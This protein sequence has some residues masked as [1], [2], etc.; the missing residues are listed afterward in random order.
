MKLHANRWMPVLAASAMTGAMVVAAPVSPAAAAPTTSTATFA[1]TGAVQTW[2]VPAGVSAA[3]FQLQ[4]AAGANGSGAQ[5]GNGGAGGTLSAVV[6]LTPNNAV[7][8]YVGGQSGFNG[9]GNG[10][11]TGGNG[12]DATDIRTAVGV[13][14]SR[15]LVAG[16]GGG[17]G[18]A[19]FYPVASGVGGAGSQTGQNGTAG[20]TQ[21]SSGGAAGQGG[22]SSNALGTPGGTTGSNIQG[23]GGGGGGGYLG[24]TGGGAGGACSSCQA[25]SGGGGGGGSSFAPATASKVVYGSGNATGNGSVVVNW[26]N[27]STT[28]VPDAQ[29]GLPFQSQLAASGGTNTYTWS[30]TSGTLPAGLTLSA[31]GLISGTP[32]SL[33]AAAVTV[34]AV[35]GNGATTQ[36]ALVVDVVSASAVVVDRTAT[37]V[38]STSATGNGAVSAPGAAVTSIYCRISTSASS[39]NSGTKV[40]A[41]PATASATASNQP[42]TCKFTGLQPNRAYLYLFYA[43][44]GGTTSVSASPSAFKT[45]AFAPQTANLKGRPTSL[46]NKGLT[47]LLSSRTKT[48]AGQSV[49][50]SL[51]VISKKGKGTVAKLTKTKKGK[52]VVRTYG[53]IARLQV[54]YSAPAKGTYAAFKQQFGYSVT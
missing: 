11:V 22:Q 27:I 33:A 17:G 40:T 32:T 21:D 48:N 6:P 44:V 7:S 54:T 36:Q 49:R 18:G 30:L 29:V 46:K 28:A 52:V 47:T 4:G 5:A 20:T 12:G 15:I 3:T 43:V 42:V 10:P 45:S 37:S 34:Q 26:V 53:K 8:V 13:P 25:G 19:G 50:V 24:G 38:T 1:Y 51:Q 35:D 39:V 16:G 41:S 31:S 23:S 9:G 2:T 14:S